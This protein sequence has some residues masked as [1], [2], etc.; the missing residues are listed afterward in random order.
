MLPEASTPCFDSAQSSGDG[1]RSQQGC[2]RPARKVGCQPSSAPGP[3]GLRC[4]SSFLE[5]SATSKAVY[6]FF[7]WSCSPQW[8]PERWKPNAMNVIE[9][10]L[11]LADHSRTI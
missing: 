5:E 11:K 8:S 1:I 6:P 3:V 7:L 9:P 10:I 2:D 4:G